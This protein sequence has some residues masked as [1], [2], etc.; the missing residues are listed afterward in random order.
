VR[1]KRAALDCRSS[2]GSDQ[3]KVMASRASLIEFSFPAF[4]LFGAVD[5]IPDALRLGLLRV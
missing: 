1:K 3:S 2:F 4:C 5:S